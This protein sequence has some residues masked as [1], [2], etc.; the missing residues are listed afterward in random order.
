MPNMA[1]GDAGAPVQRKCTE[2]AQ[3]DEEKGVAPKIQHKPI[4]E[5]GEESVQQM[6]NVVNPVIPRPTASLIQCKKCQS[7]MRT[8]NRWCNK[9]N[10]WWNTQPKIFYKYLI[11]LPVSIRLGKKKENALVYLTKQMKEKFEGKVQPFNFFSVNVLVHFHGYNQGYRGRSAS[12]EDI[13]G[14]LPEQLNQAKIQNRDLVVILPQGSISLSSRGSGFAHADYPVRNYIQKT[15]EQIGSNI[16]FIRSFTISAHSGGGY[17]L[18]RMFN[19]KG[20]RI[21]QRQMTGGMNSIILFDAINGEREAE[22]WKKRLK[23]WIK[24]DINALR[25]VSGKDSSE[26][27]LNMCI[28]LSQNSFKFRAYFTSA[29]YMV[30]HVKLKKQV[31]KYIVTSLKGLGIDTYIEPTIRN[32]LLQNYQFINVKGQSHG[33]MVGGNTMDVKNPITESVKDMIQPKLHSTPSIPLGNKTLSW[34]PYADIQ[35]RKRQGGRRRRAGWRNASRQRTCRRTAKTPQQ[36]YRCTILQAGSNVSSWEAGYNRNA[37]F[38][39]MPIRGGIHQ[40]LS[41]RLNLARNYLLG[42]FPGQGDSAIA[43]NIGLYSIS[44]LRSP[45]NAVGGRRISNHAFGIAIDVNYSGNPFIGRSA[46]TDQIIARAIQFM[47]GTTLH[48]GQAQPGNLLQIRQRYE[49]ASNAIRRYFAMRNNPVALRAH[50]TRQR[51]NTS[52]KNVRKQLRQINLDYQN[53]YLRR[54][55]ANRNPAAGFIDLSQQLVE[56]LGNQAGLLWGGQY[57][58][59]KDM[60]HFDWRNGTIKTWHRV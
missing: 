53:H 59:G 5:S 2:C 13:V 12:H 51:M 15:F 46:R 42:Q 48:I 50:M 33:K 31:E 21:G 43:R 28:Y 1:S 55:L 16:P 29:N 11:R 38:L 7:G 3:D 41:A 37:S 58:G 8:W 54:E 10:P 24:N 27:I 49:D 30:R 22:I 23:E 52:L 32:L 14:R 34:A 25:S 9:L 60:M 35:M 40:E 17:A 26:K 56:A 20:M 39:S 19:W 36:R 4:F 44:G 18:D 45:A 47:T 6:G 57:P